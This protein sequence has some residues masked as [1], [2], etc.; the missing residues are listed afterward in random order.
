MA[1]FKPPSTTANACGGGRS[2]Y[3]LLAISI[4]QPGPTDAGAILLIPYNDGGLISVSRERGSV[5]VE[6]A[7]PADW[8][9]AAAKPFQDMC[10][11][12]FDVR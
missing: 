6:R 8:F 10:R 7:K 3:A 9:A 12:W 5:P 4:D 2:E 1:P 11:P